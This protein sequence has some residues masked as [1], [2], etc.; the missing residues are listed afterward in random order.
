MAAA[1]GAP[2][3]DP[4]A[5]PAPRLFG[6]DGIRMVVGRDMP[7]GF[8]AG[9]GSAVGSYRKAAGDLLVAT[10]FRVSSEAIARILSGAAMMTGVNV[11]EM[12][13]MPT[14]C[15]Q[16]NIKA[17]QASMGVTVTASHNPN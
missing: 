2:T 17:L 4:P 1:R 15:L 5:N 3:N 9:V 11:R 13:T 16:F 8:I 12:G 7:A 6:T 10:A 14:P